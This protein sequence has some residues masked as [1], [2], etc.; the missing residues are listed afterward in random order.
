MEDSFSQRMSF[1]STRD[2]DDDVE[3]RHLRESFVSPN[4]E[5]TLKK[6]SEGGAQYVF[7][8]DRNVHGAKDF[9]ADMT[10][11][12]MILYQN[13][14][15]ISERNFY[16]VMLPQ[17]PVKLFYDI[18]ICPAIENNELIDALI[19]EVIDVTI[20]SLRDMYSLNDVSI[21]DFAVLD[22]SGEVQ[23]TTGIVKKTSLHIVL[24]NKACFSNVKFMKD[25]VSYVFSDKS[26]Y[27]KDNTNLHIDQAV[28]RHGCLRM[29]GST[30]K[31]Q[32][33]HLKI[34]N[35]GFTE[36]DCMITC[37]DPEAQM[38][39]R[40]TI[41][42]E[43]K[44][45]EDFVNRLIQAR[46]NAQQLTDDDLFQKVIDALP[47]SLAFDYAQWINVGIKLYVAGSPETYW[48]EFS[49]KC[50]KEYEYD[51]AHNKWLSFGSYERGSPAGLFRL[52][53]VHGKGDVADD[54][55][56]HTLRFMGKYNHEIALGLA[57]LY[58]DDHVFSKGV[59]YF[60]D[61]H[62]W[63]EDSEQTHVS[64]TIMTR[65]QSKIDREIRETNRFLE[66]H[67]PDHPQ[68]VEE[69]VRSK[70]LYA[71]KEKTQSGR[72]GSDWHVLEVA[73]EQRK[74]AETL[75]ANFDLIGFDN[76]VF[77][78]KTCTFRDSTRDDR[79]TLST[80]YS[81]E[82][83]YDMHE[84]RSDFETLDNFL[85]QIFPDQDILDY[86]IAFLGSC[87]SGQVS[88]ELI[89][90]WTGLSNKQTGS[91]GKSTFV[92]L[93]LMTFGDYGTCGH[94]SIITTKRE[95]SSSSNSA[96]MSLR[97]KRLVTFQEIDNEN[98][99]NMPVLKSL[100]GNDMITGRQL[101]KTQESFLPQWKL[102]VCANKLPP[103][104]SDDGGTHRR[105]R[106]VPFESK[107]VDNPLDPKWN[108][109]TN[110]YPID[111]QLKAKLERLRL[112][113]MH[114]LIEGYQRYM[115]FSSLPPCAKIALHTAAYFKQ[116][117]AVYQFLKDTIVESIHGRIY[118]REI[119]LRMGTMNGRHTEQDIVD[120]LQHYYP[121]AV[122]I[123]G[124]HDRSVLLGYALIDTLS[125]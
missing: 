90:F 46:I 99:L 39:E 60:F 37:I 73:F 114:R 113:L 123:Q 70:N 86:M 64:R 124:E 110:V 74:F 100:S 21:E 52:L 19:N 22:S 5:N 31:G 82:H 41:K 95:S 54:L 2:F 81:F 77:D 3:G 43:P 97:G 65:F 58:G 118:I 122:I 36:L 63:I 48:H 88:E 105:L 49:K 62:C 38:L 116:Q 92:S 75:D 66:N 71:I 51:K 96:I 14:T 84:C 91:N 56:H 32:M 104:S 101:Y 85:V 12:Q 93:L 120:T 67:S 61:D 83:V 117:N 30:K 80:R 87:L 45:K 47:S 7:A 121:E 28:Y 44:R 15:K 89:H 125:I 109:M 69:S 78:L 98:A 8:R 33:R 10:P 27:V 9:T 4:W 57:K 40:P 29:P 72:I 11:E 34:M 111:Y 107:F 25:Y 24:V 26:G 68:Y 59:W 20:T 13:E 16:E 102:I 106:N 103:V 50:V 17:K 112:P 35:R 94:S 79:I 1:F 76:G 18:D 23:K 42:K 115:Q 6:A 55:V 119:L 108:G 53:R